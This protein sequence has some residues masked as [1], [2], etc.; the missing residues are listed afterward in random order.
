MLE[1]FSS[2]PVYRKYKHDLLTFAMLYAFN[3]NFILSLSHD[4]VVYGKRSLLNKM[5]GDEWQKFANLRSLFGYMFAQPGKKLS[6]MGG[7]FGQW[8][9]WD[10]VESLDWHLLEENP[11]IESCSGLSKIFI[12]STRRNLP[13]GKLT[14]TIQGFNG[15]T[16]MIGKAV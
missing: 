6:F 5:P 15:S 10:H 9:E 16:F 3:E 12:G 1:Y 13:C 2:D 11:F 4:E 8:K 14:I 7:E